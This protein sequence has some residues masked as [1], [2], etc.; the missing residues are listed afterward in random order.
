MVFA[1][2]MLRLA[3]GL[4]SGGVTTVPAVERLVSA[5]IVVVGA[6]LVVVIVY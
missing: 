4:P 2:L 1:R 3:R 5:C 6:R